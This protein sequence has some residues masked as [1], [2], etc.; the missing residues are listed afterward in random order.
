MS[1][2]LSRTTRSARVTIATVLVAVAVLAAAPA[3]S[4]DDTGSAATTTATPSTTPSAGP[5]STAGRSAPVDP[6]ATTTIPDLGDVTGPVG[7]CIKLAAKF[8]NLVQGVL[9]GA[10][11]ARRSQQSAEQMKADLP[12]SLHAHA[13]AVAATFGRIADNGGQLTGADLNDTAYKAAV[14]AFGEWF[15]KDCPR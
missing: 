7:D 13:D 10:D 1:S 2:H 9:E 4:S 12:L 14:K 3:C 6:N 5:S 11:G 15:S 8:S